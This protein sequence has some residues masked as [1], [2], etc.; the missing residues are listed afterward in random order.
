MRG[1]ELAGFSSANTAIHKTC[2]TAWKYIPNCL[3]LERLGLSVGGI[4]GDS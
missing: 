2:E 4:K 1:S 3:V